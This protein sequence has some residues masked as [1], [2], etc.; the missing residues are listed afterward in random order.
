MGLGTGDLPAHSSYFD[1]DAGGDSLNNIARVVAGHGDEITTILTVVSKERRGDL[2][3][4]VRRYWKQQGVRDFDI[5]SDKD[6]PRMRATTADEFTVILQ[7]GS[8]QRLRRSG[9]R[10]CRG[11]RYDLSNRDTRPA[12]GPKKEE[13]TPREHSDFWSSGDPRRK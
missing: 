7:V 4:Q 9:S 12:R 6:M 5:N 3:E 13:L 8:R 11:L 2:L 10:L 1:K